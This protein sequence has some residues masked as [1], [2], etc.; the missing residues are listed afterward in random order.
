MDLP[1]RR[2]EQDVTV[3]SI[4]A[5]AATDKASLAVDDVACPHFDTLTV[6]AG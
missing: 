4:V 5:L 2:H 1:R 3:V 6:L